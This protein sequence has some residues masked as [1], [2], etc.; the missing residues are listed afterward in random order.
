MF[1]RLLQGSLSFKI[2]LIWVCFVVV[3]VVC[4]WV[5]SALRKPGRIIAPTKYTDRL[6][7]RLRKRPSSA[8]AG[9]G[10]S[11]KLP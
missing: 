6:T 10:R 3:T 7:Q 2:F 11:R 8:K 9:S 4:W 1:Q 5:F